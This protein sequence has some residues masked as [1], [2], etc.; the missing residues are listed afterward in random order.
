MAIN[1]DKLELQAEKSTLT[2]QLA[3]NRA[4]ADERL[5]QAKDLK[6]LVQSHQSNE[7]GLVARQQLIQDDMTRAEAQL[8]LIRNMLLK[9]TGA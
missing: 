1:K 8:E 3:E 2:V 7:T 5:K 6:L 4:L 9:E